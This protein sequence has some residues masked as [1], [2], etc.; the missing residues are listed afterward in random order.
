MRSPLGFRVLKESLFTLRPHPAPVD[1][2][3]FG[4]LGPLLPS[5]PRTPLLSCPSLL[6]HNVSFSSG[7]FD[8]F[9]SVT[10]FQ[11]GPWRLVMFSIFL[12]LS[13]HH[14]L[15]PVTSRCSSSRGETGFFS[16][17]RTSGDSPRSAAGR[18]QLA[19]LLSCRGHQASLSVF[20]WAVGLFPLLRRVPQS[21]SSR[22][23][24]CY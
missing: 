1:G 3:A 11:H 23:L 8:S 10:G 6:L 20:F 5:P 22:Y 17:P 21:P 14:P 24:I 15:G 19:P 7:G 13:T 9:P 16:R 4:I 2:P 12:T 18:V